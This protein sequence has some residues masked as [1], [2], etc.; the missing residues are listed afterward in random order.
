MLRRAETAPDGPGDHA[1]ALI[2]GK[3]PEPSRKQELDV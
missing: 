3:T 1:D 2:A